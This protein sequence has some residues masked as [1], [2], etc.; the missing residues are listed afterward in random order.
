MEK[1]MLDN[2]R[3]TRSGKRDERMRG[4]IWFERSNM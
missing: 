1:A 4:R 2:M 3:R